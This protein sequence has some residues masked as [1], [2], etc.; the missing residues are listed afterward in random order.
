MNRFRFD[1]SKEEQMAPF[2]MLGSQKQ[3]FLVVLHAG[4]MCRQGIRKYSDCCHVHAL[5][6]QD[7]SGYCAAARFVQTIFRMTQTNYTQDHG[8]I[9]MYVTTWTPVSMSGVYET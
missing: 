2:T 5:K 4:V 1:Y 7:F 9:F 8:Q 6:I 3:L